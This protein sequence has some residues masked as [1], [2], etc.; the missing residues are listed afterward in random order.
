MKICALALLVALAPP[1][2]AQLPERH[3][4][5][6]RQTN[7]MREALELCRWTLDER[8]AYAHRSGYTYQE[9]VL[10]G[11]ACRLI[12]DVRREMGAGG[13]VADAAGAAG[14]AD[15]SPARPLR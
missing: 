8:V 9:A 5:I 12:L 14:R 2:V 13:A 1:A 4:T 3:M 10:L 7:V 15:R 6:E 11:N